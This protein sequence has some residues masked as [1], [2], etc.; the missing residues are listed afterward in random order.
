M[1]LKQLIEDGMI[2][3]FNKID[4]A[5]GAARDRIENRCARDPQFV[6]LSAATGEGCDA[7][8]AVLDARLA[9]AREVFDLSVAL[10]DGATIA[11][12][13]RNGEVLNR[14]DDDLRAHMRVG[15]EAADAARFA[16]RRRSDSV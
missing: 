16:R 2:E 11:W 8:L 5:D 6:P 9:E 14:V 7:F 12:L 3:A 4:L 10:D 1:G 15:L 13:Y